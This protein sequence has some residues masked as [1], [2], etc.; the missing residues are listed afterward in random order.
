MLFNVIDDKIKDEK[1]D[2]LILYPHL[3][4]LSQLVYA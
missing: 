4:G 3:V 1:F 2:D